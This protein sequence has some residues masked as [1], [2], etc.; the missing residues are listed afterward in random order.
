MINFRAYRLTPDAAKIEQFSIKRDW[1]TD[2]FDQHA[3]RCFSLTLANSIGWSI[4]FDQDVTVV[5]DG[6][7]DSTPT[8]VKV[9]TD[10]KFVHTRTANATVTFLSQWIFETDP[11]YSL[12]MI[13]PPNVLVNGAQ[14]LTSITSSGWYKNVIPICWRITEPNKEITF[15]AG[16]PIATLIPISLSNLNNSTLELDNDINKN[17]KFLEGVEKYHKAMTDKESKDDWAMFYRDATNEDG[18]PM[19]QHEVKTLRLKTKDIN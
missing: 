2:T 19:G 17:L 14:M 16:V 12:L 18:T 11:D 13:Q 1:M 6:V 8:H 10:N 3:Y 15:K 5:W 4:S 7:S 9:L